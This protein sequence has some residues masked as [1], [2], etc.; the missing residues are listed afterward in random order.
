MVGGEPL[1]MK[2]NADLLELIPDNVKVDVISNFS[3][4]V[5]KSKVFEKLLK[6]PKVNWHISIENGG[7]RYEY[8]R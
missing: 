2:E 7:E 8:V 6:R 4:D 1:L 3:T 5:T